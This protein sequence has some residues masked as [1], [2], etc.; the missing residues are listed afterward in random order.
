MTD[1]EITKENEPVDNDTSDKILTS[2]LNDMFRKMDD[3]F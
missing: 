2:S 3:V 1:S